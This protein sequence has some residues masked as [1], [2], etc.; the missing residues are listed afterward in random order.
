[1]GFI[2]FFKSKLFCP[3]LYVLWLSYKLPLLYLFHGDFIHPGWFSLID[4]TEKSTK[5]SFYHHFF[6][7][8]NFK[9]QLKKETADA[10]N[11][12][13]CLLDSVTTAQLTVSLCS[14]KGGNDGSFP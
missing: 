9:L 4:I 12:L 8:Q 1:M 10:T 3:T 6:N 14:D 13:D 11:V 7:L 5:T 2:A